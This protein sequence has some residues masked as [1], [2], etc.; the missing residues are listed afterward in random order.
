MCRFSHI[1]LFSLLFYSQAGLVMMASNIVVEKKETLY[2]TKNGRAVGDVSLSIEVK[3]V[4]TNPKEFYLIIGERNNDNIVDG[5]KANRSLWIFNKKIS[6]NNLK[7]E[8]K[9]QDIN[10]DSKGYRDLEPFS[11]AS[12]KFDMKSWNEM[13]RQTKYAFSVN[14][15]VGS[16]VILKLH[17]FLATVEKKTTTIDDDARVTLVF[18]VPQTESMADAQ[19]RSTSPTT[20]QSQSQ[21]RAQS[22]PANAQSPNEQGVVNLSER[23]GSQPQQQAMPAD[24][25]PEADRQKDTQAQA[26]E[27]QKRT[28]DLNLFITVKNK[29]MTSLLLDIEELSTG[30]RKIPPKELDSIELVLTEMR[31]KVEYWD[32]GYT[33]ILLK[34]QTIQDKFTKF[35]SDQTIA[36]RQLTELRG[37]TSSPK[38]LLMKIGIISAV[39]MMLVMLLMQILK[40]FLSKKKMAKLQAAQM[41]MMQGQSQ[42]KGIGSSATNIQSTIS[43]I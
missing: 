14:S 23:I 11:D 22:Q 1:I 31:K 17:F 8:A 26:E 3:S 35:S 30:K 16:E 40:P 34:E 38:D 10:L 27:F 6:F 32:K 2:S 12:I 15:P 43:K 36:I 37:K 20:A 29:E 41:K 25:I 7:K 5:G 21:N 39:F 19:P 4:E 9:D 33:D 18:T 42:A 28:D 24:E 13:K